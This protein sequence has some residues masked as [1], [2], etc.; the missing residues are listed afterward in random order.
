MTLNNQAQVHV[1]RCSPE[2]RGLDWWNLPASLH[3][4]SYACQP[5]DAEELGP[6]IPHPDHVKEIMAMHPD[7]DYVYLDCGGAV[8]KA[9]GL[10]P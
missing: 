9:A 10:T 2:H 6:E 5:W 4:A 1:Y 8:S 3:V 7:C